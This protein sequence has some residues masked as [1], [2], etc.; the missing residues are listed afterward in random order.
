MVNKVKN[1]VAAL[2]SKVGLAIISTLILISLFVLNYD[3]I[4]MIAPK[5]RLTTYAANGQI[6]EIVKYVK[7]YHLEIA[8]QE[9]VELAIELILKSNDE[10]GIKYLNDLFYNNLSYDSINGHIL[11]EFNKNGILLQNLEKLCSVLY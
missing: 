3:S 2:K 7:D 10:E 9:N 4:K 6:S 5:N 8:K 11:T 1:L